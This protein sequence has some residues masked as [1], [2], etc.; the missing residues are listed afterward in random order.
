M[1][2][3]IDSV[4]KRINNACDEYYQDYPSETDFKNNIYKLSNK[5]NEIQGKN[6]TNLF[7]TSDYIM[8]LYAILSDKTDLQQ[9]EKDIISIA[10]SYN[11]IISLL[12]E[13]ISADKNIVINK[14]DTYNTLLGKIKCLYSEN[15][16][17]DMAHTIKIL[18]KEY[19]KWNDLDTISDDKNKITDFDICFSIE[20]QKRFLQKYYDID[21]NQINF[22]K[23][24]L[25]NK[26]LYGYCKVNCDT[27]NILIAD[28]NLIYTN[29]QSTLQNITN[30]KYQYENYA[31][32]NQMHVNAQKFCS[33]Q[34]DGIENK[35]NKIKG[36]N[37]NEQ[38]NTL[39]T[40]DN[41]RTL[42][43]QIKN[44]PK[45]KQKSWSR[46]KEEEL[47]KNNIEQI[48]NKK[49]TDKEIEKY[50]TNHNL[51]NDSTTH[52]TNTQKNKK[53]K[54]SKQNKTLENKRKESG[55][56]DIESALSTQDDSIVIKKD[57]ITLTDN[58]TNND[59]ILNQKDS[60]SL[61]TTNSYVTNNDS[62]L[63]DSIVIKKDN[64][65]HTDNLTNNDEILNQKDGDNPNTTNSYLPEKPY[66]TETLQYY[67]MAEQLIYLQHQLYST[68]LA[69]R[70]V[71]AE[72][73]QCKRFIQ[74]LTEELEQAKEENKTLC[75]QLEEKNNKLDHRSKISA[76]HNSTKDIGI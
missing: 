32:Y 39:R 46:K 47:E 70:R 40:L 19:L 2:N 22:M 57:N 60:D 50:C 61:N 8:V 11:I 26:Y 10:A 66:N 33:T 62:N 76:Q 42:L 36:Y 20:D 71:M 28:V 74:Q 15:N 63:D 38:E 53:K 73:V 75:S 23:L 4:E 44:T 5:I 14:Y 37:F 48:D 17:D 64:I 59:E 34:L 12:G 69:T 9:E 13:L 25:L 7:N 31:E 54:K 29:T 55:Y 51:D 27:V 43:Y 35:C 72:N 49:M 41:I 30:N 52:T 24:D 45:Y 67:S 18:N 56:N 65:T 21:H 58:L 1:K 16:K 3:Y 6:Y 68:E